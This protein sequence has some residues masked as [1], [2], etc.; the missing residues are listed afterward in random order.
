VGVCI[1]YARVCA[2]ESRGVCVG[3]GVGGRGRGEV[4]SGRN[5]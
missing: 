2:C 4:C 3:K 5:V 1:L